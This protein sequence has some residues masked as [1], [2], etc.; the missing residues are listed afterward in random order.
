[1]NTHPDRKRRLAVTLTAASIATVRKMAR[2]RG[3][4]MSSM[5]ELIIRDATPPAAPAR[6]DTP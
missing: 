3:L 5:L 1:M 2:A 6:R 4:S